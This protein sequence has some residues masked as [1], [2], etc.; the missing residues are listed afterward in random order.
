MRRRRSS[1]KISASSPRS[2][3]RLTMMSVRR[4]GG[5]FEKSFST[6][7]DSK[8]ARSMQEKAALRVAI[9][10]SKQEE[11][12]IKSV[13]T[14]K[15]LCE[16]SENNEMMDT[17]ALRKNRDEKDVVPPWL[18]SLPRFPSFVSNEEKKPPFRLFSNM[19]GEHDNLNWKKN[20]RLVK[21]V[22]EARVNVAMFRSSESPSTE[23]TDGNSF[24]WFDDE[25]GANS[26]VS[27]IISP[28][29]RKPERLAPNTTA[30][31]LETLQSRV[32]STMEIDESTTRTI[33]MTEDE[34]LGE[35]KKNLIFEEEDT[36]DV[37]DKTVLISHTPK[38]SFKDSFDYS[39]EVE[40][41]LQSNNNNNNNNNKMNEDFQF[42]Y[43]SYE[44]TQTQNEEKCQDVSKSLIDEKCSDESSI[45]LLKPPQETTS[46]F[47]TAGGKRLH[48]EKSKLDSARQMISDAT[49]TTQLRN[50]S[51][52]GFSTAG[53]KRLHVEKSK[54]DSA[55]LMISDA[56][57]KTPQATI[58][59][60][61]TPLR[62]KHSS[63]LLTPQGGFVTPQ[64]GYGLQTAGGK[65]IELSKEATE[66]A[67]RWLNDDVGSSNYSKGGG[68]QT[69]GGK[70]I[71]LSAD[72]TKRASRWLS[73]N[74]SSSSL[75]VKKSH[76][77]ITQRRSSSHRKKKFVA[78]RRVVT[79]KPK[80]RPT[81]MK[82]RPT[83]M[84]SRPTPMKSRPTP[85]KNR[86]TPM[87]RKKMSS[88]HD[89]TTRRRSLA[90][91]ELSPIVLPRKTRD[92]IMMQITPD[93]A[94]RIC[95]SSS[96][97]EICFR[98]TE[99][100]IT[101]KKLANSLPRN[102]TE[103]W[104]RNH[105]RWIVWKL[106][107][108]ERTFRKELRGALNP[109]EILSQLQARHERE[110]ERVQLPITRRMLRRDVRSVCVD[111]ES[112]HQIKL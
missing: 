102:C 78:P 36:D 12:Q 19:P 16:R 79:T 29:P 41:E 62:N 96:N 85:M 27:A 21:I 49:T 63:R 100:S 51:S 7:I 46:G 72:A 99:T 82:S 17:D 109:S 110:S 76:T 88:H 45:V 60:M 20:R 3:P 14:E 56:T 58:D 13:S 31:V 68:L 87:K 39:E 9:Y 15:V 77:V 2:F 11:E 35:V 34:G 43:E 30:G 24:D 111:Y 44:F 4:Q 53:G 5:D 48:V 73:E 90:S 57:M 42:T 1:R 95:F 33:V 80:S 59:T 86:Q 38:L 98:R 32:D 61:K 101:W 37:V 91:L 50:K 40:E 47:S 83:P 104:V 103:T 97:N 70:K 10:Q 65:K 52:S 92:L 94:D 6:S 67:A 81:P 106:A 75:S 54:L 108:Y 8:K 89:M 66:R 107:S 112:K 23:N 93:N 22:N 64:G 25:N 84:K 105:Y 26:S 55:R 18:S 71:Q 74:S 69:A 28:I